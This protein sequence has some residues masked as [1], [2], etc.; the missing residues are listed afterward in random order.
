[1]NTTIGIPKRTLAMWRREL[2]KHRGSINRVAEVAE[3]QPEEISMFLSGHRELTE[4]RMNIVRAIKDVLA[5]IKNRTKEL[6]KEISQ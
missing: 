4:G 6:T 5:E 1:M 2:K 3:V